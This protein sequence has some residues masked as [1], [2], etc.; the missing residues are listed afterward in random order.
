MSLDV[1]EINKIARV[2]LDYYRLVADATITMG[3]GGEFNAGM[4]SEA[5]LSTLLGRF[6][7]E[8]EP[9][10]NFPPHQRPGARA[11]T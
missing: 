11:L 7:N 2:A 8:H 9:H 10:V 6:F 5:Q 3:Q 4:L 1:N